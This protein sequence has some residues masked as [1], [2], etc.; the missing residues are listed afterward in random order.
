MNS[1][2]LQHAEITKQIIGCACHAY[3]TLGAGFLEPVCQR[4]MEIALKRAGL[5]FER[6]PA[7]NVYLEGEEVGEYFADLLM[8]DVVIVEIKAVRRLAVAHEIQLVNH[9]A[10]TGLEVGLLI[11]FEEEGIEIRRKVRVLKA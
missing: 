11:N 5:R 4:A 1:D 7:L 10:A 9:L 6:Q 2:D 8:P 3:N